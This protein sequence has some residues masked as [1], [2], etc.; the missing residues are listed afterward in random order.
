MAG[1]LPPAAAGTIGVFS[2]TGR[3]ERATKHVREALPQLRALRGR[4]GQLPEQAC[5]FVSDPHTNLSPL[6]CVSTS[7]ELVLAH[8]SGRLI[9]STI[10][11]RM[12]SSLHPRLADRE[13]WHL[14]AVKPAADVADPRSRRSRERGR[15]CSVMTLIRQLLPVSGP[16]PCPMSATKKRRRPCSRPS[17]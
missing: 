12:V 2:D 11:L 9:R 14:L 7:R 10:D 16:G 5:L 13:G 1:H 15:G 3:P 8:G 6:G 4:N 17:H